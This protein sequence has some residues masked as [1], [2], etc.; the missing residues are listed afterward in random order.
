MDDFRWY[1]YCMW[2]LALDIFLHFSGLLFTWNCVHKAELSSFVCFIIMKYEAKQKVKWP[3]NYTFKKLN[4]ERRRHN[5]TRKRQTTRKHYRNVS[6]GKKRAMRGDSASMLSLKNNKFVE[7]M[8]TIFVK[9]DTFQKWYQNCQMIHSQLLLCKENWVG[10]FLT[11]VFSQPIWQLSTLW[12][13]YV[14]KH[15]HIAQ[16]CHLNIKQ[17]QFFTIKLSCL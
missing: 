9:F 6:I 10:L 7:K 16:N 15:S 2:T 12:W 3:K 11:V 4:D 8:L 17:C 5:R 14:S 1:K 13:I